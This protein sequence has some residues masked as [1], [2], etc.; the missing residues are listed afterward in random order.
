MENEKLSIPLLLGTNR[1][2]RQSEHVARWV[3][4]KI[5]EHPSIETRYFD[6]RDFRLP[7][8]DYGTG[9]ASDFPDWRDAIIAADGLVIAWTDVDAERVRVARVRL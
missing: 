3:F 7:V 2:D 9:I 6:V 1:R 4:R 8:D 5:N